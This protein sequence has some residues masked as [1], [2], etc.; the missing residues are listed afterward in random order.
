MEVWVH[1]ALLNDKRRTTDPEAASLFFVPAYLSLSKNSDGQGHDE[2][3]ENL[4]RNCRRLEVVPA[5]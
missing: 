1:R 4:I 2:R 3:L 5:F